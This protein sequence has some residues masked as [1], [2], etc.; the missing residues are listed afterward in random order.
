V[1]FGI[2]ES[3]KAVFYNIG[4]VIQSVWENIIKPVFM[5]LL[6]TWKA[7]LNGIWDALKWCFNGIV[8]VVT[9][10]F[11]RMKNAAMAAADFFISA[12]QWVTD[13]VSK[14]WN[15]IVEKLGAVGTWIKTKLVEPIKQAFSGLWDIVSKV[16]DKILEKMKMIV[17]PIKKLWNKLFPKDKFKDVGAAYAEGTKKGA[18]NWAASQSKKANSGTAGSDPSATNKPKFSLT[19]GGLSGGKAGG[20]AGASAGQ[21]K[22]ININIGNMIGAWNAANGYN[23]SRADVEDKLSESIARILGLADLAA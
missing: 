11:E 4:I 22:T 10:A 5:L 6:N 15:W 18:E 2:W 3:I 21:V 17:E 13:T 12:F 7:I 23:E 20:K 16:F 14:A 1:I 9:T 19:G 8:S